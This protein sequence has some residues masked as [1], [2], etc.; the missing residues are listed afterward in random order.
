M[1]TYREIEIQIT[2]FF[3]DPTYENFLSLPRQIKRNLIYYIA[4]KN[5]DIFIGIEKTDKGLHK[6]ILLVLKL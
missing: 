3:K 6:R 5:T 2:E 1:I 4:G